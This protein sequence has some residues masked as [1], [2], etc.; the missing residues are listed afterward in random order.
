MAALEFY[1]QLGKQREVEWDLDDSQ[2]VFGQKFPG[3][4]E[5]VR[6]CIVMIQQP[7]VWGEVLAHFYENG[8]KRRSSMRN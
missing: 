7:V 5:S 8:I 3:E 2:V 6:Q 4:K 1:F